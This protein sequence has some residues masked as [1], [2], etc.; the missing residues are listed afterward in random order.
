MVHKFKISPSL[1]GKPID[2]ALI[3]A[4]APLSRKKLRQVLDMGGL[5]LNGKRVR[6]GSTLVHHGDEVILNYDPASLQQWQRK[7]FVAEAQD[8][9]YEDYELLAYNKPPLLPSQAT[10]GK[11]QPHAEA[12]LKAYVAKKSANSE[13]QPPSSLYLCHR[14]DKE[15]SGILLAARSHKQQQWLTEQFKQR[16]IYKKY[17]ALCYG[18]PKQKTWTE[19]CFL[20]EINNKTKRVKIVKAGGRSSETRFE[21]LQADPALGVSLLACYPKTGRA[22]QIRVHLEKSGFPII[23]DKTYGL[24][25]RHRLP[26]NLEKLSLSHHFLH[27]QELG[28]CPIAGHDQ[29]LLKAPLPANFSE[30]LRQLSAPKVTPKP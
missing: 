19:H 7:I 21:L 17:L 2:L 1:A 20:T 12:V 27:A 16:S 10:A 15:T 22:H 14:L 25:L 6:K 9:L 26:N 4:G 24:E 29:V 18:V 13:N 3:A 23:G 8:I 30:F 28:F 5:S 11:H